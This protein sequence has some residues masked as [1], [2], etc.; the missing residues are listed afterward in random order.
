MLKRNA[1]G[2]RSTQPSHH[3]RSR[4]PVEGRVDLD[5]RE[6]LGVVRE[7]LALPAA[8]LQ[9][10]RIEVGVI[11]PIA[12][13]DRNRRSPSEQTVTKLSPK[14]VESVGAT[15][16]YDPR[17][18]Y[19]RRSFPSS[20]DAPAATSRRRRSAGGRA[21]IRG[22][23]IC[24]R[25]AA[26]HRHAVDLATRMRSP[27]LHLYAAPALVGIRRSPFSLPRGSPP[28]TVLVAGPRRS[29]WRPRRSWSGSSM[30]RRSDLL[31]GYALGTA[32][33]AVTRRPVASGRPR[34]MSSGSRSSPVRDLRRSGPSPGSPQPPVW[35]SAVAAIAAT[36]I[37][38]APTGAVRGR[39]APAPRSRRVDRRRAT[40]SVRRTVAAV[41]A[42]CIGLIAVRLIPRR[43]ARARSARRRRPSRCS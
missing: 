15:R 21:S 16:P 26:G 13:P 41:T 42:M 39:R 20:D 11:G 24:W 7:L 31:I 22:C 40:I 43:P 25:R 10:R 27:R 12:G 36:A 14:L 17:R 1:S 32:L 3:R 35:H 4:N 2:V 29:R 8:A 9:L 34:S 23:W 6:V 33:A 18:W 19:I 30:R 5:D 38:R 37:T 28:W